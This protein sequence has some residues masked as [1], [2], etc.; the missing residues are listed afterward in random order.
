MYSRGRFQL[1]RTALTFGETIVIVFCRAPIPGKVKTRLAS[2]IGAFA[3]SEIYKATA[4]YVV[5]NVRSAGL[6]VA[7]FVAET[8][9]ADR[10]RSW[11]GGEQHSQHGEDL[12][13]RMEHA[14]REMSRHGYQRFIIVGTDVP[15]LDAAHIRAAASALDQHDVV[16][17]PAHDGGY[18]II[19]MNGVKTELFRDIPWSTAEVLPRSQEVCALHHWKAFLLPTVRDLDTIDDLK[20]VMDEAPKGHED[21]IRRYHMILKHLGSA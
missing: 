17:G 2:S 15:F 11:L 10:V 7:I 14:V 5:W 9:H 4:E 13:D 3:S 19:G 21:I 16:F 6:P 1:R 12:G 8:E 18:Y 20:A